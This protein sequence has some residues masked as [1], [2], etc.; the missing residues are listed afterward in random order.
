MIPIL[1]TLTS[2]ILGSVAQGGD[3]ISKGAIVALHALAIAAALWLGSVTGWWIALALPITGLYWFGFRTGKQAKAELDDKANIGKPVK[4]WQAYLLPC[5]IAAGLAVIPLVLAKAWLYIPAVAVP[6]AF[7]WVP[8]LACKLFP[9]GNAVWPDT[10]ANRKI[11]R[12][13]RMKVEFL[14]GLAPA[15]FSI[16]IL[17]WSLVTLLRGV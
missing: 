4:T 15:G 7:L 1:I 8:P 17:V 11:Q 9:F 2:T 3:W 5:G 14:V 12:K 16:A 10:E 13:Q 6:F